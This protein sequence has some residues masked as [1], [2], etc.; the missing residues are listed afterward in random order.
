M[1]A[2]IH[3][4]WIS[5][6]HATVGDRLAQIACGRWMPQLT[7][8]DRRVCLG[9]QRKSWLTPCLT[10]AKGHKPT[11]RTRLAAIDCY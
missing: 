6:T 1:I 8:V 9:Q 3:S 7:S 11:I 5:P 10:S 4:V 2:V